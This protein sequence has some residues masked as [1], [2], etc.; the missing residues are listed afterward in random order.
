MLAR[1]IVQAKDAR[2]NGVGEIQLKGKSIVVDDSLLR[3]LE[4][5]KRVTTGPKSREQSADRRNFLLIYRNL[6]DLEYKE[7]EERV[8][9]VTELNLP[10]ALQVE[11]KAHQLE[12]VAWLQRS[13]GSSEKLVG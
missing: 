5:L 10:A 8:V 4:Q 6:E 13:F 2:R 3:S 9:K 7:T 1:E 11:L 12:G